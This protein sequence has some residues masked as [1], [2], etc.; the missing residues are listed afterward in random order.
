MKKKEK[1]FEDYIYSK[2][3]FNLFNGTEIQKD[4]KF[5]MKKPHSSVDLICSSYTLRD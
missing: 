5:F 3:E 2:D 4:L 1:I